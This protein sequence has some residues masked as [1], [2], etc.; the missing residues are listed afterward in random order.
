MMT[1]KLLLAPMEGV[2]TY[3]YRKILNKYYKGI[4]TF[5][6]P[7]LSNTSFSHRELMDVL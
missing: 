4:D 7:F 2:T 5:Y 1:E 3:I 6:T